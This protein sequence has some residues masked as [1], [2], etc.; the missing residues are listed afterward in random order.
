L[1]LQGVLVGHRDGFEAM[2]RAF[3]VHQTRPVVDRQFSWRDVTEA[4]AF[5]RAGKHFGKVVL[6]I[7]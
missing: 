6:S 5:Q 7:D 4:L 1:R 3:D 2:T